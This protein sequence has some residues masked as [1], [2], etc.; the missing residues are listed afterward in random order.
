LLTA[1]AITS[2]CTAGAS[3]ATGSASLVGATVAETVLEADPAPNTTIEVDLG[4]LG[5][6]TV[7]MNE[8]IVEGSG[9]SSSITVNALRL[10]V[11]A[12]S[13]VTGEVIVSQSR[14][15]T[16]PAV[17]PLPAPTPPAPEPVVV[18]PTFTG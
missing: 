16:V 6:I 12:A 1:D 10:S 4:V 14:C 2:E 5:S 18:T 15:G 8:Q 7:V 3:G 13:V 17:A 9:A 11:N